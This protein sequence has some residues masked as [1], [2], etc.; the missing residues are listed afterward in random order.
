M[1]R[2]WRGLFRIRNG[3]AAIVALGCVV[4]LLTAG[5]SN[6]DTGTV[7]DYCGGTC[8]DILP[9]GEN[10][11]ATLVQILANQTLG[12]R[13][14]HTDD[15]LDTY[16]SLVTGYEQLTD[17]S[18]GNY[19]NSSALGVPDDDVTSTS[20]PRDDVTIVR[21]KLGIPHIYGTTRSG[22]EYGAGYAAA[23]DRLWL[24]DVF[25]HVGRGE[26]TSFAGGAEANR[27]LEQSF[28]RAAPY[29]EQDLQ[30]QIDRI[31]ASGPR[32]AQALSDVD[33]YVD[34]INDYIDKA[35]K[36]R[37]FPGEYDLTGHVS[38][39]TNKGTIEHFKPTDLVA[40]AAVV[41]AL[42]GSGGGGEVTN[43]L[44]KMAF[45]D[46]YGV[47]AGDA[48]WQSFR[49]E[50]DPEAV[51]TV[52][53]GQKFPYGGAGADAPSVAMPDSGSVTSEPIVYDPTGSATSSA[54]STSTK[55]P[56]GEGKL[57][58][59]AGMYD[60]GV[61]PSNLLTSPERGM[62]NALVV[63]AKYAEGGHPIA[64]FGPQTGYFAPQ[65]LM[66]EELEG[67]GI[68][69]RGAAFAGL[70]M[71]VELGRGQDYSWS[72]TSASQDITDTY[73][74]PLCEPDGSAP[75]A[76]SN[77]YLYHGQCL[78]MDKLEVDD[79]WKP[80]LA[81]QTPEGSYK[82]IVYR[83]KYGLVQY[84]ATEGGKPIAYTSLRSSY[85]HE[86]DSIIGFQEFNDPDAI[87]DAT[88]FQQAA[89]DVN[90]T[91][92]W[93]YVD[94]TDTAYFNSGTEPV[95]PSDVDYDLPIKAD[96]AY[97]WQGWDPSTNTAD[98]EPAS[99][100]PQSQNQD[101]YV[102]WNNK[103]AAGF[104]ASTA[105]DGPVQRVNMLDDRVSALVHSGQK[106]TR[107]Q[108]VQAMEDAANVDLRGEDVLP[109]ALKVIDSAPVDD[110]DLAAVVQELKDWQQ[111]GS[112]RRE[113]EAGDKEYVDAAAI[114]VMDAWWPL[115][116]KAE[117]EPGMGEDAYQALANLLPINDSPSSGQLGDTSGGGSV[118]ETQTH[119]GSSFQYG[120]WSYT[121][122]DLRG[123]LG[124]PV[125]AP[126]SQSYCGGGDLSACRTALLDSLKQAAAEPASDVY[127][128]DAYCK[129]GD[130]WCADSIVQEPLGGVTD[131]IIAWQ[132][133]PTYQQVVQY[134]SH[135]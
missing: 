4:A 77:Y 7:T 101:Y 49:E 100:H 12:T 123:V 82:L 58:S 62:S 111:A 74:V 56:A 110:P 34:G 131:P 83:T 134:Q 65:L 45:D 41:G 109:L 23:E 66:D 48:A 36:T 51:L 27:E 98:Y 69:A 92:N 87:H 104:S 16:S 37:T 24:M 89:N 99:A 18:I 10:G 28:W 90:Y 124:E 84:R 61:L 118:N 68:S 15:Q 97:E 114:Q 53:D 26:L 85:M 3:L 57:K 127:P 43:A 88:D 119:K 106:V 52:H 96:P 78:A 21:D 79:S 64:V 112:H 95:R 129:A 72:A 116:V 13:P 35:Y 93:F 22:T 122:K 108:L 5:P 126:L 117:F 6:A 63:S 105:G 60:N 86:V 125:S 25:R 67:P 120:W 55:V 59:V 70:S 40:I 44:A 130:Q 19:Y 20:K 14:A 30:D 9:P 33:S 32:G 50:N 102:S 94:S 71:Y 75:T 39:I 46:Q 128:A 8:Y 2:R 121:S 91:F 135:R 113:A 81:D 132:N 115:L 1:S 76:D 80:T 17:D 73:A 42:F 11:N 107:A 38:P 133:R 31:A 54:V 47:T 29:T 103:Q